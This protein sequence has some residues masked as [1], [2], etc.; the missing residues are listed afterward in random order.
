MKRLKD[1]DVLKK[2][3]EIKEM[4]ETGNS[5]GLAKKIT[6]NPFS[7]RFHY[8][9]T[10][11]PEYLAILNSYMVKIG[12]NTVYTKIDGRVLRGKNVSQNKTQD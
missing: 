2:I 1:E 6:L 5:I 10:T 12:K 9:V 7:R 11:H 3:L 4:V 8:K